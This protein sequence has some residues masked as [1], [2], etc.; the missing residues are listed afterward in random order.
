MGRGR[1]WEPFGNR[2]IASRWAVIIVGHAA[3]RMVGDWIALM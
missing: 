2:K 1:G 3:N